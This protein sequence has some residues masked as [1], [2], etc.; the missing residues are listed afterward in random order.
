MHCFL[1][2]RNYDQVLEGFLG[3]IFLL[4]ASSM[5]YNVSHKNEHL[6]EVANRY[7]G[8]PHLST[9][10]D[11]DLLWIFYHCPGDEVQAVAANVLW[12]T[13]I[14]AY[15][16]DY[17][18]KYSTC[19]WYVVGIPGVG[20]STSR[21]AVSGL[22]PPSH[23]IAVTRRV[24]GIYITFGKLKLGALSLEKGKSKWRASLTSQR[25]ILSH[26]TF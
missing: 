2:L 6:S 16:S 21:K 18:W 8:N 15:S 23:K 24:M 1:I 20:G 22:K 17:K 14:N 12:V 11:K 9:L 26:P 13:L 3:F 4:E 19:V 25:Y 10:S 7:P 5:G